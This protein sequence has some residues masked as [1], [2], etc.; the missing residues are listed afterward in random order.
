MNCISVIGARA[1]ASVVLLGCCA[2][3]STA[4]PE[5]GHRERPQIT[6]NAVTASTGVSGYQ[7]TLTRSRFDPGPKPRAY[8][9][10]GWSK[11]NGPD[12]IFSVSVDNHAARAISHPS[13]PALQEGPYGSSLQEHNDHVLAYFVGCGIPRDQ[14]ARVDGSPE[15]ETGGSPSDTTSGSL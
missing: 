11:T 9:Q 12:G 13:S 8:T 2:A 14:I 1:G 7:H 10:Y 3:C 6:A 4:P 5:P 15:V